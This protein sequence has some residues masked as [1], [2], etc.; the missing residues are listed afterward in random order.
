M[1]INS[2]ENG[3]ATT[4][5][6]ASAD[7]RAAKASSIKVNVSVSHTMLA[8]QKNW[9]ALHQFIIDCIATAFMMFMLGRLPSSILHGKGRIRGIC[10]TFLICN[11]FPRWRKLSAAARCRLLY[12]HYRASLSRC[13]QKARLAATLDIN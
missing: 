7:Q 13:R 11:L 8:L 12:V 6:P 3:T 10:R 4:G 2:K 1:T 5:Y 9:R